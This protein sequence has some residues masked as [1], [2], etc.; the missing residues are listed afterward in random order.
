MDASQNAYASIESLKNNKISQ[1]LVFAIGAYINT[2]S[3]CIR[4]EKVLNLQSCIL[5]MVAIETNVKSIVID[6]TTK[7]IT[8]NPYTVLHEGRATKFIN[9]VRELTIPDFPTEGY[10]TLFV[11]FNK[12]TMQFE[13][14]TINGESLLDYID[15]EKYAI[16]C[17]G[18]TNGKTYFRPLDINR[19]ELQIILKNDLNDDGDSTKDKIIPKF[20]EKL[21]LCDAVWNNPWYNKKINFLGDSITK[22]EDSQDNYLRMKDDNIACIAKE[23]FGFSASRNYGYGGSK[24]SGTGNGMVTRYANMNDDADLVVLWGG[25][26]DFLGGVDIGSINDNDINKFAYAYYTLLIGLMKKYSGKQILA[27]TPMHTYGDSYRHDDVENSAGYK[28]KDYRDK[29]IEICEMLGIPCYDMWSN[30]GFSPIIKEMRDIYMPDGLHP[31]IDGMRK[32]IGP[33]ICSAIKMLS[34]NTI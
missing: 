13:V 4:F 29:E 11:L 27:I 9:S 25:V 20:G 17:G 34:E 5:N 1:H 19:S 12:N 6:F 18:L 21:I 10:Y 33:K 32:Y 22:G 15:F 8:I 3:E 14:S 7:N 16:L 23:V 2:L 30:M 31:S 26:N 28:L 24:I